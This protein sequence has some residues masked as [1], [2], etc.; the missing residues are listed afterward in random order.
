MTA[1]S[2][3]Q[4]DFAMAVAKLL[5]YADSL[6]YRVAFGEAYRPPETVA[7]FAAKGIG[8]GTSLHPDRMAFDLILRKSDGSL[9]SDTEDHAP[10]GAYWKSLDPRARWGGDFSTRPDGGHYSFCLDGRA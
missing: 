3:Q 10:L 6:G 4:H 9:L 1:Y 8:S 5:V 7:L 2:Q